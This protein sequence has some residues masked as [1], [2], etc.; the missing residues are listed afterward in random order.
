MDD[1]L[2]KFKEVVDE[3]IDAYESMDNLYTAKKDLLIKGQSDA[4]WDLDAEILNVAE[5][6][7]A[8]HAKRKEVAKDLGDDDLTMSKAIEKA[9]AV[10]SPLADDFALQKEKITNLSKSLSKKEETNLTLIKHGL[11]MVGKTLDIIIDAIEPQNKQYDKHGQN[12]ESDRSMI[13]SIEEEV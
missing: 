4:L 8:L 13:S 3:E 6:I 1:K 9:K 5:K 7:K 12:I 2:L 10:N 11:T